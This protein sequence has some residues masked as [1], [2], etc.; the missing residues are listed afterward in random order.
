MAAAARDC[1]STSKPYRGSVTENE[2]A[3]V[4]RQRN[5]RCWLRHRARPSHLLISMNTRLSEKP[6][7]TREPILAL[8]E[9]IEDMHEFSNIRDPLSQLQAQ[10]A[11]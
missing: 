3:H 8:L 2:L 1:E 9:A 5:N 11:I 6:A 7:M 10:N 4:N